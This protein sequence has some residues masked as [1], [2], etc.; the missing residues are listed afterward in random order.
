MQFT[1]FSVLEFAKI[2]KVSRQ[3]VIKMIK[4]GR[5][6]ALRLTG[7][8]KSPYRIKSSEIERVQ[9]MELDKIIK[10]NSK[11]NQNVQQ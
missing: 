8:K 2:L 1:F 10:K 3:T 5:I 7:A 9:I 11:D 4:S 6:V